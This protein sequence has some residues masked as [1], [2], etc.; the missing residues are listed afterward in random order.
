MHSSSSS[1]R[2]RSALAGLAL[3]AAALPLVHCGSDKAGLA[4]PTPATTTSGP[5][6]YPARTFSNL[7]PEHAVFADYNVDAAGTLQITADWTFG[8]D[9]ID[10]FVVSTGCSTASYDDLLLGTGSCAP[11]AQAIGVASKPEKL[12]YTAAAG[13]YRIYVASS[14]LSTSNESGTLSVTL[15]R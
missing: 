2:G 1:S 3:L 6:T 9:D 14:F 7:E 8:D 10:V 5:R 11:L 4:T 12:N 13:S 15:T